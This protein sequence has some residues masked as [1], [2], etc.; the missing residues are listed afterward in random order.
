MMDYTRTAVIGK[1]ETVWISAEG[2]LVKN[3]EQKMNETVG[4]KYGIAVSN[5]TAALEIAA[6][7]I[8]IHEGD[9]VI[10]QTVTII[11]CWSRKAGLP[12]ARD[13]WRAFTG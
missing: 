2:P 6:Q 7:A 4:R 11:S 13:V 9:K 5:W 10:M 3:F 8:G 12:G 1:E